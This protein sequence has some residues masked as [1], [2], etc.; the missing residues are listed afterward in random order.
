MRA[1]EARISEAL[2]RKVFN[3]AVLAVP[4]CG[5]TGH[6]ADL[7]VIDSKSL[8]IIDVE[9]KQSRQDFKQDQDK[10]KWWQ[11]RPWS[12][13][14]QAPLRREWPDKVWKHYYVLPEAIYTEDLLEHVSQ[15]SG[16]LVFDARMRFTVK[17]LAKP[18][19][20]AKPISPGDAIDIARLASLRM[21]AALSKDQQ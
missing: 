15:Q 1:H 19:R 17:R 13:R 14:T 12:R 21:W 2:V 5:W 7:L 10:S 18:C 6:E 9:I 4:N 3:R 11:L 20:D 16:I 8:R